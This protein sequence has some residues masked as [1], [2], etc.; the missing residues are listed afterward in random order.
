MTPSKRGAGVYMICGL[1]S[2]VSPP[3]GA[4]AVEHYSYCIDQVAGGVYGMVR[5]SS[6]VAPSSGGRVRNGR[7]RTA[8]FLLLVLNGSCPFFKV[9]HL[10][11]SLDGVF[12]RFDLAALC[13]CHTLKVCCC[14]CETLRGCIC[15]PLQTLRPSAL[16]MEMFH[17]D[18]RPMPV[19]WSKRNRARGSSHSSCSGGAKCS[20]GMG[21]IQTNKI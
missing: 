9:T 7:I 6:S 19:V 2:V 17:R 3:A 5:G 4:G 21:T 18:L 11:R 1:S 15:G 13:G 12:G 8:E 20:M 14:C 10:N 16:R